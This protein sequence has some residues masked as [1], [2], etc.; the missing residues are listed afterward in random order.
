MP[1]R[2]GVSAPPTQ[3]LLDGY[4]YIV[5]CLLTALADKGRGGQS[6]AQIAVVFE[7]AG[8]SWDGGACIS[9]ELCSIAMGDFARR[10][11]RGAR[12]MRLVLGR[13]KRDEAEGVAAGVVE[14]TDDPR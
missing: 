4:R 8:V 3:E 1:K 12:I 2:D 6:V 13:M 9:P 10:T 7:E 14:A 11:E 5:D